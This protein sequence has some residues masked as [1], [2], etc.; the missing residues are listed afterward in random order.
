MSEISKEE[1]LAV[2]MEIAVGIITKFPNVYPKLCDKSFGDLTGDELNAATI[3]LE[4]TIL[5]PVI[6]RVLATYYIEKER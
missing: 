4:L 1:L 3:L 5:E 6:K 2:R